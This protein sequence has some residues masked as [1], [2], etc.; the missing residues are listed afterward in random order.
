M[1]IHQQLNNR[2]KQLGMTFEALAKRSGVSVA[3]VKRV[4]TQ[5]SEQT[6]FGTVESIA[7]SLGCQLSLN[8][9]VSPQQY[10]SQHARKKAVRLM[11][12]L[13][14]TSALEGQAVSDSLYQELTEQ[15]VHE[16]MAASG[17]KLWA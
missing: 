1:N 10:R 7:R 15:T 5:G 9:E 6:A 17:R 2:R 11:R 16:L 4:L 8:A 14:G 12:Q 3:T 13:Q